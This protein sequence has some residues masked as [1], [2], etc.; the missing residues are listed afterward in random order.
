MLRSRGRISPV[1]KRIQSLSEKQMPSLDTSEVTLI[2][3]NIL[4]LSILGSQLT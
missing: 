2:K 1:C 3:N 4:T